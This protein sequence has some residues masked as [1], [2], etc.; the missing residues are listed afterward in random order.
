MDYRFTHDEAGRRR[1]RFAAPYEVIGWFLELD[2]QSSSGYPQ[3]LLTLI[4][5]V[6]EGKIDSHQGTGNAHTITIGPDR[7][8]IENVY[9]NERPPCELSLQQMRAILIDWIRFIESG[10]G[11]SN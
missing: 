2:V 9:T 6:E 10:Q 5:D 8:R 1:A 4:K 7:V 3:R 11:R